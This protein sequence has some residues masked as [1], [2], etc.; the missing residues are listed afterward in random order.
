M[1][2]VVSFDAAGT[3]LHFARPVARVYAEVAARNGIEAVAE[4]VDERLPSAFEQGGRMVPVPGESADDFERQWWKSVLAVAL[5]VSRQ[6]RRLDDCFA[7]LFGYYASE[8]A[9]RIHERLPEL[10]AGLQHAGLRLA[11]CSNF[12]GRLP[13][14]L[15]QLELMSYFDAVVLPRHAGAEKP[16]TEIFRYMV[17]A[18]GEQPGACLHV[19]DSIENDV[20]A[21]RLAGLQ[22]LQWSLKPEADIRFAASKLYEALHGSGRPAY[23][24]ADAWRQA[25]MQRPD[26]V[27]DVESARR[28]AQ[29]REHYRQTGRVP[30][31]DLLADHELFILGKM[32]LDEYQE[33]LVFKHGETGQGPE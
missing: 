7:E 15:K 29:A 31:A 19:G 11:I 5:D 32:T 12:D 25:A 28:R 30:S 6:D 4:K 9:W 2:R 8:A 1:I 33:Y 26:G 17:D 16:E 24:T 20:A 22:G 13:E 10:L 14:L 21:A 27:D 18:M 23:R 3:L